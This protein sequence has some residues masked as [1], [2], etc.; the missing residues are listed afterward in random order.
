AHTTR[1]VLELPLLANTSLSYPFLVDWH[2]GLLVRMGASWVVAIGIPSAILCAAGLTL[3]FELVRRLLGSA[4]G[5]GMHLVL[6]LGLGSAAGI[7]PL[8]TDFFTGKAIWAMDYSNTPLQGLALANPV[9]S[10]FFPQ[11]TFLFGFALLMGLIF[12]AVELHRQ[13]EWRA[14]VIPGMLLGLLPFVHAHT[15]VVGML[16]FG[17][18]AC[19]TL[20]TEKESRFWVGASLVLMGVIAL[21]QLW[22][23]LHAPSVSAGAIQI[24][25]MVRDGESVVTFWTRQLGILIPLMAFGGYLVRDKLR[26]PFLGVAYLGAIFFFV[27]GNLYQF[28]PSLFDNL[29]FMLYSLWVLL[30]PAAWL[31]DGISR[32]KVR[33]FVPIFIGLSTLVGLHAIVRDFIPTTHYELFSKEDLL[34]ADDL[35]DILPA[36]AVVATVERHNNTIAALVGRR[37]VAGYSG[38][39]WSYGLTYI[40]AIDAQK[41]IVSGLDDGSLARE[42]G[43]THI[44]VHRRDVVEGLADFEKL[45]ETYRSVY[46]GH[47]WAVFS[48]DRSN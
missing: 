40:P 10:H 21:P 36:N 6:F 29:K 13:K 1:P 24:G 16:W 45:R 23:Q 7:V 22:W 20:V 5:A 30:I 31:L 11:R 44:A 38:W 42:F 8:V 2:A 47:D 27:V 15:A 26:E 41:K 37:V 18:V 3:S 34:A 19:W 46:S 9:T 32:T 25:W 28:H 48:V 33:L 12:I 35:Q 17:G 39:L 43:V 4:S 14:L